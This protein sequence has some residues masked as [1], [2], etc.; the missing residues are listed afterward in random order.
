MWDDV[1]EVGSEHTQPP[2][3]SGNAV[4]GAGGQVPRRGQS[5]GCGEEQAGC[6]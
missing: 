5:L 3:H 1:E 4:E 2:S 6:A